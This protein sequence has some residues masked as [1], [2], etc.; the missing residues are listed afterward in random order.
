[1]LINLTSGKAITRLPFAADFRAAMARLTAAEVQ[2]M[3][4]E[5][6]RKISGDE[7]HTA[8]WMPGSDWRGT[9]F[10]P[11]YEKGAKGNYDVA[12]KMFGL[13]VW[14]AFMDHPERWGSGRYE[15]DGR[16][17]GSRTYFRL[18]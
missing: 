4:D 6:N 2:A 15:K 13:L 11:L 8:G 9:P 10:Q 1:M 12:A 18:K 16:D 7:I 3:K 5:L 14:Q 17:I